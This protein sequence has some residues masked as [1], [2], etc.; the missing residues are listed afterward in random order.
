MQRYIY[1]GIAYV[2][3]A[4]VAAANWNSDPLAPSLSPAT[5]ASGLIIV[6]SI[7]WVAAAASAPRPLAMHMLAALLPAVPPLV[8]CSLAL[9][10]TDAALM[11]IFILW[12]LTILPPAVS[13]LGFCVLGLRN[14]SSRSEPG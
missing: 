14:T 2:A 12:P 10:D 4:I 3:A 9:H 6:S 5:V 7:W 13:L 1:P 11:V 8:L